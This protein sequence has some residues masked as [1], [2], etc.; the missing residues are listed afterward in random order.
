MITRRLALALR[1]QDWATIFIEFLLVIFG[2]LIALQ[3]DQW[4]DLRKEKYRELELLS[5]LRSDI[6][7]D[8]K[9]LQ[10]ADAALHMVMKSGAIA[11][12]ANE[13][14]DCIDDCWKTLVAYFLA[15]QWLD[16]ELIQST[17]NELRAAG[18]PRDATLASVLARYQSLGEQ[19]S[20]INA[21]LPRYR[22]LVRSLI[23]AAT[24]QYMWAHCHKVQARHQFLL[25]NC[26]PPDD[27][28]GLRATVAVVSAN[29]EVASTLNY[30]LSTAMLVKSTMA[31]QVA[32]AESAIDAI[33]D[34]IEDD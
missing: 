2:V 27:Q 5:S 19:A 18:F 12:A 14:G 26:P 8:I 11:I 20:R 28:S 24:Q 10:N 16:V 31:D 6:R 7:E 34:Y 23:P 30:W 29:P 15:S 17:Y 1:Q 4:N 33:T 21:E 32:Y 9:N 3:L 25:A 13:R 22:S